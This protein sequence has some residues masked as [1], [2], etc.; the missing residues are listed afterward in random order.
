MSF[1]KLKIYSHYPRDKSVRIYGLAVSCLDVQAAY[2][3]L[4]LDSRLQLV[5][6]LSPVG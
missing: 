1:S 4:S 2:S 6:K 3:S 5:A